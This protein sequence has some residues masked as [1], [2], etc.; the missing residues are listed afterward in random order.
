M[1]LPEVGED[2]VTRVTVRYVDGR[3]PT[4]LDGE[5]AFWSP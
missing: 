1:L 5:A 2:G 3:T 4:H